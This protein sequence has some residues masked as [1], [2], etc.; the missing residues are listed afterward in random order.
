MRLGRLVSAPNSERRFRRLLRFRRWK[1]ERT[2]TIGNRSFFYVHL[3]NLRLLFR[4]EIDLIRGCRSEISYDE[5][6]DTLFNPFSAATL[7]ASAKVG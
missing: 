1:S 4:A 2:E 6:A 5:S 7:Y 3:R